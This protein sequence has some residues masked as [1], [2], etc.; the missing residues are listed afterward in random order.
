MAQLIL[1]GFKEGYSNPWMDCNRIQLDNIYL[2]LNGES[3]EKTSEKFTEDNFGM[4]GCERV[5]VFLKRWRV[6]LFIYY[7][8]F[9]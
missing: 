8:S 4:Y 1:Y 9:C 5:R 7:N 3:F 2:N 6:L